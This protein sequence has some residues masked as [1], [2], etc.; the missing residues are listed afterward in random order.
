MTDD[1][2]EDED[3]YD[4]ENGESENE[5]QTVVCRYI[6]NELMIVMLHANDNACKNEVDIM[7]TMQN[8]E[9]RHVAAS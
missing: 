1:K 2:D 8:R 9:T 6:S 7:N 5:N 4:R 3:K